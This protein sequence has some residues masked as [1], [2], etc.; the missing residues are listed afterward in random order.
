[1]SEMS[2]YMI[3]DNEA[4]CHATEFLFNS[5]CKIN[6]KTY[7]NPLLFLEE[8]SADWRGCIIVDLHM[9]LM[10][11]IDLMKKVRKINKNIRVIIVSGHGSTDTAE[12]VLAAGAYAF[13][14]KPY[15]TE[16]LLEQVQRILQ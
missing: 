9:P 4:V 3:D 11:G 5:F 6:V 2:V 16:H 7:Q 1:M 14:S 10:N 8:C 15:K 12:Q 13:I